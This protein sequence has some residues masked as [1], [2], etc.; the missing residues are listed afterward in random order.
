M[1]RA[2]I[3]FV[4]L[5]C[6]AANLHI[7]LLQPFRRML[8]ALPLVQAFQLILHLASKA[9]ELIGHRPMVLA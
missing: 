8:P 4:K 5:C 9:K 2:A 6:L 1:A 3:A 7:G